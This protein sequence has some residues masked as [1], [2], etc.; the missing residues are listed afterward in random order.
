MY[1]ESSWF[2]GRKS[3]PT[4][5]WF[6]SGFFSLAQTDSHSPSTEGSSGSVISSR[7]WT[8]IKTPPPFLP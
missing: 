2:G 5:R 8:R 4:Y 7:L 1:A 6:V 3:D